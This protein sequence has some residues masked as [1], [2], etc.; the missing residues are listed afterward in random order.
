MSEW[1]SAVDPKSGRAYYYNARTRETQWR[2]PMEL[3][4]PSEQKE[5]AMKERKQKEF[6]AAMERNI[7]RNI[8]QGQ[9]PG[10]P[11]EDKKMPSST[12]SP[13]SS[14]LEKPRMVRTISGMNDSILRELV[15]RVPSTRRT[16]KMP[17]DASLEIDDLMMMKEDFSVLQ[18]SGSNLSMSAMKV[19]LAD[20]EFDMNDDSSPLT[21]EEN[22][23]LQELAKTA[24][25]MTLVSGSKIVT[26]EDTP[27]LSKSLTKPVLGKPGLGGRRNTC[28]TIYVGTTM[29]APDKDATIKVRF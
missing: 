12:S 15:K 2:K 19:S 22:R 4:S 16:T 29:S 8:A 11:M 5:M 3:A 27:S 21:R 9:V 25:Q 1:K 24:E 20:L 17:R 18:Q 7:L 28:G 10:T 26:P 6:F 23:V 14:A 13:S